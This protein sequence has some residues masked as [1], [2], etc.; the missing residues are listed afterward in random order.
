VLSTMQPSPL[1]IREILQHGQRVFGESEVATY[2]PSGVRRAS[3]IEVGQRAERLACGLAELGVSLGDRVGTLLWNTQEHQECYLAIPSMGAVLHTLNLRLSPDHLAFVI[4]HAQDSVIVVDASTWPLLAVVLDR[5]ETVRH[6][7]VVGLAEVEAPGAP[8]DRELLDYQ[9]L[10]DNADTHFVWPDLDEHAAAAMCYTSGTTGDPKGVVYS[11]RS[12][13]LHSLAAATGNVFGLT[14]LDKVLPVVPMFHA[15]AWG[16]PFAAWF[17]GSDL[18]L[19]GRYLQPEHLARMI[20]AERPTLAGAVPTIWNDLLVF[21]RKCDTD[22]SSL[23]LVPCGGSAV[24]VSLMRSYEDEFDVRIIQAWGMTETSPLAAVAVPPKGASPG[25]EMLWRS[26]TGRVTAGVQARIVD[27]AGRVLPWD[28]QAVGEIQVRGPWITASYYG[29]DDADKFTSGWLRTGDVASID[30]RGFLQITDRTKDVIKSGGEW[31]SSVDLENALMGH[32]E[33][34]EAA[35]IAIPDERW[36]ERPL[37]CVVLTPG[38]TVSVIELKGYLEPL[39]AKWWLP[40]RWSLL[41]EV[42]KTSV[43]KFDKKAL[44]ASY[45]RGELDHVTAAPVRGPREMSPH[46]TSERMT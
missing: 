18:L 23:R 9:E 38:A 11:H 17:A 26:K 31:I 34:H 7:I 45:A 24:P 12:M 36:Q 29:Q 35:V 15:N 43:G 33:V 39:V 13:Y 8:G 1:L 44:R 22:L 2:E 30:G 4:N 27:D 6:I 40:E 41:T 3:F 42:P 14:E 16:L 5:L 20:G 19:P 25:E 37:A 46:A 28:G 21:A 10:L 32:P